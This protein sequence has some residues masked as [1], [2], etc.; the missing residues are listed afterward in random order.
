MFPGG[1]VSTNSTDMFAIEITVRHM[2]ISPWGW[3]CWIGGANGHHGRGCYGG[4]WRVKPGWHHWLRPRGGLWL[5]HGVLNSIGIKWLGHKRIDVW[6]NVWWRSHLCHG[7]AP[8][9][10]RHP[11]THSSSG[12]H[13][14]IAAYPIEW[15]WK[16]NNNETILNLSLKI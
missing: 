4:G 7:T 1:P 16:K 5:G 9:R 6:F 10:R 14:W 3:S 13:V 12:G 15:I 11:H 2:R 8:H